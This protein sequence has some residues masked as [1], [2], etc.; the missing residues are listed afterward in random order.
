MHP[1]TKPLPPCPTHSMNT[2]DGL[3][4][5]STAMVSLLRC[6]TD[7]PEAPGMPIW[8][9]RMPA[10]STRASTCSAVQC[11]TGRAGLDWLA[12]LQRFILHSKQLPSPTK[13][14]VNYLEQLSVK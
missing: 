10:S 6:S 2:M 8:A 11:R 9:L 3:A 1:V 7:K 5:S 4:T 14:F 13:A 12:H